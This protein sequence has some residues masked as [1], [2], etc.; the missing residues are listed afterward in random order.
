MPLQSFE[1]EQHALAIQQAA[2]R[3]GPSRPGAAGRTDT[4]CSVSSL[5]ADNAACRAGKLDAP[6]LSS[7]TSS[8][9]T[10]A[11]SA[12]R[13]ATARATAGRRSV[14]S[15]PLR[16]T[17]AHL[18][19]IEPAQQAIAVELDLADPAI[20]LGRSRRRPR[21]VAAPGAAAACRAPRPRPAARRA[22]RGAGF[23]GGRLPFD[24]RR[25]GAFAFRLVVALDQQP[26]VLPA[27]LTRDA[28]SG[29]PA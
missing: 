1:I 13:P 21:R 26:V 15:R 12:R 19:V 5:P 14:Q 9:S 8:P 27:A 24:R 18:A 7:A 4:R 23:G 20:A 28:A 11:V 2:C 10:S 25:I 17:H 16:V 3:A 29:A 22:A 6:F